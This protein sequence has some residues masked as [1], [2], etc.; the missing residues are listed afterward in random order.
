MTNVLSVD[1]EKEIIYLLEVIL[2]YAG[3]D[4]IKA[5]NGKVALEQ[6]CRS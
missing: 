5:E 2:A 3:S 6:Q 4:T 1:L